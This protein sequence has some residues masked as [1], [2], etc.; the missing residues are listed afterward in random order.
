MSGAAWY[1]RKADEYARLA[2]QASDPRRRSGY[3]TEELR[4]RQIAEQIE[5]NEKNRFG[6]DPP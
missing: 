3:E 5:T 2:Q 1:L 6:S 4:W